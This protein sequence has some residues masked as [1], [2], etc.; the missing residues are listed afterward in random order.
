M[1]GVVVAHGGRG[2]GSHLFRDEVEELERRGH[3]V[4]ATD[5]TMAPR[6][7]PDEARSFEETV[8]VQQRALD[9]LAELGADRFGFYGHSLGA[10]RGAALAARDARV[11]A[12]VIA[13]MGTGISGDAWDPGRFITVAGP[14]RLFQRGTRDDVVP[15]DAARR[16]YE[17]APEP[18]IWREYDCGHGIGADPQARLDRYAF[19]DEVLRA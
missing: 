3:I 7:D 9:R 14:A 4:I 6:G 2:P 15:Y 10:A 19:L 18:K 11:A 17:L 5:V 1:T 16:L 13:G 12:L 8:D